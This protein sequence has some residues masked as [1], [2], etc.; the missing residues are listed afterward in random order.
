MAEISFRR[1]KKLDEPKKVLIDVG[2]G[3]AIPSKEDVGLFTAWRVAFF[4]SILITA[5]SP[6]LISQMARL[7]AIA[8]LLLPVGPT[9]SICDRRRLL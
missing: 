8:V 7:V 9:K 5:G 2:D 6:L 3:A 4:G 1:K